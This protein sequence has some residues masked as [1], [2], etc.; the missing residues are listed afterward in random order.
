MGLAGPVPK[1]S[2][3]K[4]GHHKPVDVTKAPAGP[5]AAPPQPDPRWHFIAAR[6]YTS[7]MTSGQSQFYEAS[8]WATAYYIAEAMHRGLNPG[9]FSAVLFAAVMTAMGSLGVTEGDRRRM[10]L[11]LQRNPEHDAD[12][13][14]SVLALAGY[15]RDAGLDT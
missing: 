8:D 5:R 10:G 9:K 7:L 12:E 14:A 2:D 3:Q 13:D 15:R 11:E 4:L 6:F 1:R